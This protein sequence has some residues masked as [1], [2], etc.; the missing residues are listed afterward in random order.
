MTTRPDPT[1]LL[2][3]LIEALTGHNPMRAIP[4]GPRHAP[5]QVQLTIEEV[6]ERLGLDRSLTS[7]PIRDSELPPSAQAERSPHQSD[8]PGSRQ[9]DPSRRTAAQAH[10]IAP[11]TRQG[12]N[13]T[14]T[15]G[16]THRA[17]TPPAPPRK[18]LTSIAKAAEHADVCTRTIR[19]WIANG[20]ITGY[21]IGPRLIKVDLNDIDA[22]ARPIPT[23]GSDA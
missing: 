1:A 18:R 23:A 16:R 13:R 12:N 11:P 22:L 15:T 20:L 17:A 3:Q 7:Q 19:R 6:A 4:P 5:E 8:A 21:R 2:A 9:T 14:A 10:P